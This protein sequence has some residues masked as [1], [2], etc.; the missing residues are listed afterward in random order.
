MASATALQ[1]SNH[2]EQISWVGQ[3]RLY[4]D[5]RIPSV[6]TCSCICNSGQPYKMSPPKHFWP[7]CG[8]YCT[9][10]APSC[11]V[12]VWFVCNSVP[13]FVEMIGFRFFM[14]LQL[15]SA[16]AVLCMRNTHTY[17][18]AK[19]HEDTQRHTKTL[20]DTHTTHTL[21]TTHSHAGHSVLLVPAADAVCGLCPGP[22]RAGTPLYPPR[23]P[24]HKALYHH[25]WRHKLGA[26]VCQCC[27]FCLID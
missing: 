25:A 13:F 23:H 1:T 20:T 4:K 9:G 11:A 17:A 10:L 5:D 26:F 2:S 19:P 21:H 7:W 15:Q 8:Y 12:L 3:R 22:L 27:S 6:Y 24:C 16:F 18:H 14:I